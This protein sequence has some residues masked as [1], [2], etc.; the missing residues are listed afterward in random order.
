MDKIS[1]II[2]WIQ[3]KDKI[4]IYGAGHVAN[5]LYNIIENYGMKNKISAFVVKDTEKNPNEINGISVYQYEQYLKNSMDIIIAL[6]YEQQKNVYTDLLKLGIEK[7]KILGLSQILYMA[8]IQEEKRMFSSQNYWNQRYQLG[9]N[10]GSG[11]YNKLAEYKAAVINEFV[12]SRNIESVI[13]W[14]CGDG[15]QLGLANYK[16]YI[17]YDVSSKAIE[18]C[19]QKFQND[20]TKQFICCGDKQFQNDKVADLTLSLDVI[21]HLVEDEVFEQYMTRLFTSSKKYVCIYSSN[22]NEQTAMHVKHRKFTDWIEQ[23]L[24]NKWA[25][26][27]VINN[28]YPYSEDNPDNTSVSDF[29]FY[30]IQH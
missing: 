18:I 24:S 19:Q 8:I 10:S 21:F 15:N 6:A 5:I 11:S 3:E 1:D 17:G 4:V 14:G 9:G 22:Y 20:S 12:K 29:Y 13:E 25:L 30:K 27:K 28:I 2:E 26:E 23:N 16:K 7:K